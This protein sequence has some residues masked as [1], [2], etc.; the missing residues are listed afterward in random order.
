MPIRPKRKR[1]KK[2]SLELLKLNNL[3]L[4]GFLG[5]RRRDC[6]EEDDKVLII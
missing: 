1:M 5:E 6:R 2:Q 4:E 3:F